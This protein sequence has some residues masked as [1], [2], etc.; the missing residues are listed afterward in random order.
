MIDAGDCVVELA[1]LDG[2]VGEVVGGED[3]GT[4]EDLLVDDL[5]SDVAV[6]CLVGAD[7]VLQLVDG[8]PATGFQSVTVLCL[9]LV[10][11]QLRQEVLAH[12]PQRYYRAQTTFQLSHNH[13][14][15]LPL[16]L[17]LVVVNFLLKVNI[18]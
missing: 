13:H 15:L 2:V 3:A 16:N 1:V 4:V 6:H 11:D 7:P 9:E 5:V 17:F 12:I 8:D 18:L 10:V 14:V